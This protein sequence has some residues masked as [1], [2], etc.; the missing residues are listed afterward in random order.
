M[1]TTTRIL[2]LSLALMLAAAPATAAVSTWIVEAEFDGGSFGGAGTVFG[3]FEFDTDLDEFFN[4]EIEVID[5]SFTPFF[6][7]DL[8]I[9]F[10]T[11]PGQLE[12]IQDFSLVDP[13][14]ELDGKALLYMPFAMDLDPLNSPVALDGGAFFGTCDSPNCDTAFGTDIFGT[15]SV[16]P[17]PLPAAAWLFI[18]ALGIFGFLGKRKAAA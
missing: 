10:G 8:D 15:A 6:F 16:T 14:T 4:V 11:V 3:S 9:S 18:S 17:V 1:T 7:S 13:D 5:T 12:L 2:G